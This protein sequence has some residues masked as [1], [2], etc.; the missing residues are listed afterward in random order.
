LDLSL[1]L[2]LKDQ[3]VL[4]GL[5]GLQNQRDQLILLDQ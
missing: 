1:R 3:L 4:L 2:G 5:V